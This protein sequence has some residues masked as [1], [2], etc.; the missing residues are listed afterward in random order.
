MLGA[1]RSMGPTV[2]ILASLAGCAYQRYTTPLHT[3]P[4]PKLSS[5]ER[6][7]ALYTFELISAEVPPTK[8]SGLAWDEDGSPPDPFARLFVDGR[9]VWE[10]EVK[11][12]QIKPVWHVVLPKNVAIAA[13]SL[14][15]LELWD[16]DATISADPIGQIEH[17]GLPDNAVP[18]AEA[19]LALDNMSSVTVMV[20][21]P[22]AH[23]GVGVSVEARPN[24][25]KVYAVEPYSPAAR[26]G[27]KVGEHIVGIGNER[28]SHMGPDD[29]VSEL[30]LVVDRSHKLLVADEDGKHEREVKLDDGY[31]W[32]VL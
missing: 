6:P 11:S 12:D 18:E 27:I 30:S 28:V 17:R 26:A 21:P 14:F 2:L 15:R 29:A 31:V 32:L 19:R 23:K 1:M 4:N 7:A 25:L 9:L 16:Y 5:K 22:R 3:V 13:N 24:A 8:N 20:S 10:S